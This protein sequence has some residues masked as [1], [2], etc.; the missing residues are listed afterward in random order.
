MVNGCEIRPT[1]F[2]TRSPGPA[3]QLAHGVL[4]TS[5]WAL[6]PKTNEQAAKLARMPHPHGPKTGLAT[7]QPL[8]T[9]CCCG[10]TIQRSSILFAGI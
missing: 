8:S 4:Y 2:S 1:A 9:V 10:S 7:S 3:A 6:G 5:A